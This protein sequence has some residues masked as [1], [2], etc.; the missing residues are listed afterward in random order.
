MHW[1]NNLFDLVILL[2][3]LLFSLSV[4]ESAHA[5]TAERFG[6]PTARNMGRVSLNPIA[7]MDPI[8]TFIMPILIILFNMPL[9]GW[10]KPVPVNVFKLRPIKKG[11]FWVS[12]AGPLSNLALAVIVA[13]IYRLF[14]LFVPFLASLPDKMIMTLNFALQSYLVLNIALF[15]FNLLPI[16]PLDGSKILYAILPR[17]LDDQFERFFARVGPIILLLLVFTRSFSYIISAP[18]RVVYNALMIGM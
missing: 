6:D 16:F 14:I 3:G 1:Q 12:A 7:H 10:G 2:P 9:I 11:I 8:G 13:L 18:I 4:H 5:W 17:G 15:V